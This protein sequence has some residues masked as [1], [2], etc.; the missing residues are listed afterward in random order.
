MEVKNVL[1]SVIG[2]IVVIIVQWITNLLFGFINNPLIFWTISI[3]VGVSAFLLIS[4]I[5]K[6]KAHALLGIISYYST[7][8]KAIEKNFNAIKNSSEICTF[9][10]KGHSL[11]DKIGSTSSL[12]HILATDNERR[13]IKCL[14][15]DP[16]AANVDKYIQR[17]IELL[18][19][20]K[21]PYD[22]KKDIYDVINRLDSAKKSNTTSIEYRFFCEELKWSLFIVDEF[23]LLSFYAN[24]KSQEAPC[25][26]IQRESLL[27]SA[28]IK[29]FEDI[30]HNHSKVLKVHGT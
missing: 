25:F 28:F 15:L 26:K 6:N 17:R 9:N 2:G 24:K 14:L 22:H 12:L 27:G 4:L 11:V 23:I 3:L 20:N 1:E 21:I 8:N 13:N 16:T 29:Y 18:N 10:F 19:E 30:W 7:R 5:K